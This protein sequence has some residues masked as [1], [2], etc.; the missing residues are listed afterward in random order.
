MVNRG[1]VW[2]RIVIENQ[3]L[4]EGELTMRMDGRIEWQCEHSVGHTVWVE[5][6]YAKQKAHWSHGCDWCC[7]KSKEF[8]AVKRRLK[9]ALG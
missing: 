5:P 1:E 4:K 7:D 6:K 9:K 8:K 3:T 2:N